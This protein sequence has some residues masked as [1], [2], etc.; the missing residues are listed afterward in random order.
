MRS[1]YKNPQL[2]NVAA[3]GLFFFCDKRK[4]VRV[5]VLNYWIQVE[6]VIGKDLRRNDRIWGGIGRRSFRSKEEAA[7]QEEPREGRR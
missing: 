1:E 2:I 6:Q 7:G 5:I 3:D 4:H